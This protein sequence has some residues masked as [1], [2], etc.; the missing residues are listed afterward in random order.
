MPASGALFDAFYCGR[1]FILD[2][3]IHALGRVRWR[4]IEPPPQT[5]GG[6]IIGALSQVMT[7]SAGHHGVQ[8]AGYV[9]LEAPDQ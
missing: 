3:G 4:P 7:L 9:R 8:T 6:G 5:I 2:R 1:I